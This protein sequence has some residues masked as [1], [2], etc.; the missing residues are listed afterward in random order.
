MTLREQAYEAFTGH[1]LARR[2]LPGQF[3]TQRDLATLTG[4]PLGAIREMIPRL[5]AEGLVRA[6]PQRGLQV[7][8]IEPRLVRDAFQMRE[9]VETAALSLFVRSATEDEIAALRAELD[10]VIEA[11]EAGPV[12]AALLKRA[13]RVDWGLHD[14]IVEAMGN[15]LIADL[16]RVNAIRIRMMMQE[17]VRLSAEVL[18]PSLGEHARILS[19]LAARDEAAALAA[20][21]AHLA[22]ARRRALGVETETPSHSSNQGNVTP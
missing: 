5:E 20:L 2:L 9:V 10:G 4:F 19:A 22:S 7:V 16:H 21:R 6:F 11:A 15:A 18:P 12:D 13:Q 17:S 14:C 3:V 8:G 1:L